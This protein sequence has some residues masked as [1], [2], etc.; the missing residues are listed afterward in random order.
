[1][2]EDWLGKKHIPLTS[3]ELL[4]EPPGIEQVR[5]WLKAPPEDFL[6]PDPTHPIVMI[7]TAPIGSGLTT[8][9]GLLLKEECCE[10]VYISSNTAKP[11]AI[12]ANA[13]THH[14]AV[15]GLSKII[16]LDE[17][18]VILND[19]GMWTDILEFFKKTPIVR[20]LCLAHSS[21]VLEN[22]I[23]DLFPNKSIMAS[24]KRVSLVLY[25][26][27][28]RKCIAR[29]VTTENI[30]DV[31]MD[32][33]MES[34]GT[35]IRAAIC[36]LAMKQKE[37]ARDVHMD[38]LVAVQSLLSGSVTTVK[39]AMSLFYDDASV[40]SAGI[41]ENY[42]TSGMTLEECTEVADAISYS[43][44]VDELMYGRQK[45]DLT[46]TYGFFSVAVPAIVAT[47]STLSSLSKRQDDEKITKFGTV[48][49]KQHIGA[50]KMKA[51]INSICLRR[52]EQGL[53]PLHAED[54][55]IIRPS[56]VKHIVAKD[57]ENAMHTVKG[58]IGSSTL[59]TNPKQAGV[60]ILSIIRMWKTK[61]TQSNHTHLKK[62]IDGHDN[63]TVTRDPRIKK[64]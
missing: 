59:S 25:P 50:Q 36:T 7:V 10:P 60:I 3:Q 22:R 41:H 62:W 32:V 57:Q 1:M 20:T 14:T 52:A 44:M 51:F 16:V 8:M 55:G 61:Y 49:S 26:E 9:A 17:F 23:T 33:L 27:A 39:N 5:A 29:I 12:L 28:C 24:L 31:D 42:Y 54:L 53:V 19:S 35:D 18:D 4:Y 46:D 37:C 58:L 2:E 64:A 47:R 48:W 21:R 13:S 15:N 56:L 38:A 6:N 30:H 34:T 45:W 43:S 63:T 40:I 11:R